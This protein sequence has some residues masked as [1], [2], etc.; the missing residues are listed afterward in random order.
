MQGILVRAENKRSKSLLGRCVASMVRAHRPHV[1]FIG[2]LCQNSRHLASC[3]SCP[4]Q[5]L[6]MSKDPAQ[7]R[8]R[9]KDVRNKE[10]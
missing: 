7:A 3:R 9:R 2:D 5:I 8:L 1:V 10:W 6:V 4:C